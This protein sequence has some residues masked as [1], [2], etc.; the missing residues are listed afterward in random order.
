MQK[1]NYFKKIIHVNQEPITRVNPSSKDNILRGGLNKREWWCFENTFR[2]ATKILN[3]GEYSRCIYNERVWETYLRST[4]LRVLRNRSPSWSFAV[5]WNK[6]NQHNTKSRSLTGLPAGSVFR[7]FQLPWWQWLHQLAL[8]HILAEAV[9]DSYHYVW[10]RNIRH[11]I[12]DVRHQT[13]DTRLQTSDIRHQTSDIGHQTPDISKIQLVV[14]YQCCV[15]IDW[16]TTRLY[17]IA[18]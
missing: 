17:V 7:P 13:S 5:L 1:S 2:I 16:A 11:Q 15:L 10:A 6:S 4:N 8:L 14:Y 18:H 12:S 3:L 9:A